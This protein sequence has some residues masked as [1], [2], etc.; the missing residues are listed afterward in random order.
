M[1]K[2]NSSEI[3]GIFMDCL[4]TEEE[5]K[6][7]T[8][9]EKAVKSLGIVYNVG[10]N[11]ERLEKHRPKIV[12]FLGEFP[13]EFYKGKGGGQSFLRM[14]YDRNGEQWTGFHK[15]MEQLVLLG[16]AV[17]KVEL[18]APKEMWN[19]LPGGMPYYVI[20]QDN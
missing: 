16:Q 17:G 1:S 6:D 14:C 8:V 20:T 12:E 2:L 18:C 15:I 13:D 19:I 9:N 7:P 4:H 11:K 10:F 5:M 3:E